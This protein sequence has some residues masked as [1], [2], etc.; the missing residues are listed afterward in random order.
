MKPTDGDCAYRPYTGAAREQPYPPG[1]STGNER[2]GSERK[3]WLNGSW[4]TATA[5]NTGSAAML[6]TTLMPLPIT[7]P[8]A[9]K[10]PSTESRF[11]LLARFTNH[12]LVA[13]FG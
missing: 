8:N 5:S 4:R 12:W 6:C 7:R 2:S 13:L 9:V 3:I 1:G 11:V 10:P